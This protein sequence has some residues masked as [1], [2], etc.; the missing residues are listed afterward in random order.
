MFQGDRVNRFN[1]QIHCDVFL[2]YLRWC[3]CSRW[4]I[5]L[6][7]NCVRLSGTRWRTSPGGSRSKKGNKE[8]VKLRS[9]RFFSLTE[10]RRRREF[11]SQWATCWT[12]S[13]L[14]VVVCADVDFVTPL[15]SQV[16]YEG[17]VDDIF[18]I[19]CGEYQSS[20]DP[21]EN[22]RPQKALFLY[23]LLW[24]VKKHNLWCW[25]VGR[26]CLFTLLTCVCKR[27]T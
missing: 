8:L 21:G 1:S 6:P 12:L 3:L 17:L 15:C 9:E 22:L 19:K 11:S 23:I 24:S 13:S 14:T 7:L 16:V 4:M 25:E 27:K 20:Y 5:K 10:V 2:L 26:T 18:R